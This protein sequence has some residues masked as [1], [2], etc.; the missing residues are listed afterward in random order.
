[1]ENYGKVPDPL[2]SQ[3]FYFHPS[4]ILLLL[5]TPYAISN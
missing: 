2:I 3:P 4:A 1:M 5:L